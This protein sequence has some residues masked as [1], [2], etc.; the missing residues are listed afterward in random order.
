[1]GPALSIFII[2]IPGLRLASPWGIMAVRLI[3]RYTA[4]PV[5]C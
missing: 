2:R 4:N 3:F 1:M 5:F